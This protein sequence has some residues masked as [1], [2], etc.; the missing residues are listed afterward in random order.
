MSVRGNFVAAGVV[1]LMVASAGTSSARNQFL[2]HVPN[3]AANGCATCHTKSLP[4]DAWNSFGLDVKDTLDNGDP[5]WPAICDL[6]SDEDG[7]TNGEELLDPDCEWRAFMAD[8]GEIT[9]VSEPGNADSP[10]LGMGPDDDAPS[11][12]DADGPEPDAAGPADTAAA[13]DDQ[14]PGVGVAPGGGC[15]GGGVPSSALLGLLC[16]L[17]ALRAPRRD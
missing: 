15:A 16:G 14:D 7:L 8:P 6:D 13:I 2:A 3:G 17:L 4:P 9:S 12:S 10:T 1:G 5:D 11:E